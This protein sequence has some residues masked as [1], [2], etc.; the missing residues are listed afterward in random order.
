MQ[1]ESRGLGPLQSVLQLALWLNSVAGLE[2]LLRKH[3][4]VAIKILKKKN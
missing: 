3:N 2:K 1:I 4:R